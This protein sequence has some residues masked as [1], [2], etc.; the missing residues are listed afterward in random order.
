MS[1][2]SLSIRPGNP[3]F[4]DLPWQEP[5]E[6]WPADRLVEM[7]IGVHR[8]PIVFVAYE[9]GIYAVKENNAALAAR[10]FE[11]L[12]TLEAR[13]AP[14]VSPAGLVKRPWLD[15]RV[16]GAGVVITRY[17]D[18][19]FPYRELVQGAGFGV[20]RD[21]MLDAFAGLL[22][23][24]HLA[25]CFWGDCSLSNVLYRYDAGA[26]E[27]IMVDAE[28]TTLYDTISDGRRLED[29]A[30]MEENLAGGMAD[31]AAAAGEGLDEADLHLGVDIAA[32]YDGLWGELNSEL[33]IATDERYLLHQRIERLNDLGFAVDD[34][35]VVPDGADNR[36]RI[37]VRAG[38][39]TYHS[40]RLRHLTGIE[41]SENQA[42]HILA[43]IARHQAY[44][45][46]GGSPA[47]KAVAIMGW[48]A[49]RF[50]PFTARIALLRPDFDPVQ[51]YADY[52]NYRHERSVE[53]GSDV[54][55]TPAFEAW[56]G[57]GMPGFPPL[58]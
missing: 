23:E 55:S 7:P 45:S 17:A 27:T 37:S 35:A 31:I 39:R 18:Y 1:V 26:I 44:H 56:L 19:A 33:I 9:Q 43:D 24:L 54:Q 53:A 5:V 46:G 11:N 28:T 12:R 32:R 22:V 49:E 38:G 50:E 4:L 40:D 34:I 47:E 3:D 51:G 21:Q 14:S 2:P 41:A 57:D 52:L 10:E 42:M 25:G 16:E 29:L 15:D 30:I 58:R 20:R 36:I 48:R 6:D 8:H 13:S